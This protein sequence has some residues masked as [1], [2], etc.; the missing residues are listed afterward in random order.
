MREVC[1]LLGLKRG[2]EA[3][4]C[5]WGAAWGSPDPTESS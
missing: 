5:G 2:G 3:G 4:L 1:R